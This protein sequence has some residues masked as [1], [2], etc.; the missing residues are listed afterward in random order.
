MASREGG[1]DLLIP[2]SLE[3]TRPQRAVIT[4]GDQ[5]VRSLVPAAQAQAARSGWEEYSEITIFI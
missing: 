5:P 4:V 2:I 1:A 3:R